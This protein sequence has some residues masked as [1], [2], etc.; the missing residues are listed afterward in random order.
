MHKKMKLLFKDFFSKCETT[1]LVKYT[2]TEE[3]L[4]EKLHF[5]CS[6]IPL[7]TGHKLNGTSSERL[8]YVQFMSWLHE[9]IRYY[10]KDSTMKKMKRNEEIALSYTAQ[11]MKFSIKNFSSKCDQ[12]HRKLWIWS[13]LLKKSLTENFIF[14]AVLLENGTKLGGKD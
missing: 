14:C 8:V 10:L 2:F 9:D 6:D 13:H 7:D 5:L 1:N 3:I 11:K 12:I 4:N